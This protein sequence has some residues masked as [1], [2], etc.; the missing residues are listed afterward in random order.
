MPVLEPAWVIGVLCGTIVLLLIFGM[1]LK[2]FRL[3]GQAVVKLIIGAILLFFLNAIGGYFGVHVPINFA[4][5]LVSG[6]LGVPGVCA[7]VAIRL[8]VL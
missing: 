5:S 1:P 7:L 2:F 4:T 3:A 6:F 8:W